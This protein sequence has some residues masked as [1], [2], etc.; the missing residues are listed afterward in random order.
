MTF[1]FRTLTLRP[2]IFFPMAL[3]NDT[4]FFR[5]IEES[6]CPLV[7]LSE[8]PSGDSLCSGYALTLILESLGK[9]AVL[10]YSQTFS[11]VSP[12]D[13]LPIPQDVRHDLFGARDFVLI[14]DTTRNDIGNVRTRRSEK[15]FRIYL[16]PQ[17]GSIDPRDFSFIPA[18]I[19]YDKI[20]LLGVRDKESL[21][22]LYE[23]NPDV[24]FEVPLMNIDVSSDNERYAQTN[25]VEV[26][27]SSVSELIA[28]IF[29]RSQKE[30]LSQK[31]AQCLLT[32]IVSASESFQSSKT[33]PKSLQLASFLIDRGAN[34]HEV[35]KNLYKKH[36]FSLL[37]LI[38]KILTKLQ[39]SESMPLVWAA[40]E[41]EDF[42]Q[43]QTTH[44]ELFPAIERIRSYISPKTSILLLYSEGSNTFSGIFRS[45]DKELY[46][47]LSLVLPGLSFGE[48][49]IFRGEEKYTLETQKNILQKITS[50]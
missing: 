48:Y 8:N 3:N 17:K 14:F 47:K 11:S 31:V 10:A 2:F 25:M 12:F 32:G 23:D 36:S 42:S 50:L 29:S 34:Q 40:L 6:K 39:S 16:T 45:R 49:Y 7:V 4:Q 43:S 27:S 22:K 30:Y 28:D 15:E 46:Q 37:K 18:D 13:F 5:D 24:F 35:M 44:E 1:S 38:G 21:G 33:T 20:F 41:P 26:T 19:Q 9:K